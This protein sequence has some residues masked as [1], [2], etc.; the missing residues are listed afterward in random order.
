MLIFKAMV[1]NLRKKRKQNKKLKMQKIKKRL[2][3]QRIVARIIII[4][5]AQDKERS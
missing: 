2:K 5:L 4:Y 3:L 1:S